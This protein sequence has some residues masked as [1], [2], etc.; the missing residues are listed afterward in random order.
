MRSGYMRSGRGGELPLSPPGW[1]SSGAFSSSVPPVPE[2]PAARPRRP[3]S[4]PARTQ[5][6]PT[7]TARPPGVR[8][9]A[10]PVARPEL[11]VVAPDV[12][13]GFGSKLNVYAEEALC[14]VLARQLG[15]PVKWTETRSESLLSGH[16]G[17]D[18]WQRLTLAS[19]LREQLV[20][21]TQGGIPDSLRSA[22]LE[23]F[24][25]DEA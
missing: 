10:E 14:L 12:G 5:P 22:L 11:R 21:M 17:R 18:Q 16:H 24:L 8:S 9:A 25:A 19:T 4:D 15:V 2:G 20:A 6:P 1:G 23:V 7:R 13:G 3:A